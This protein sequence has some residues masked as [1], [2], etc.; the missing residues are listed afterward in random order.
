M[1]PQD[2]F[3]RVLQ[4]VCNVFDSYS[5]VLFLPDPADFG[6][7]KLAASFSLGDN[8]R[9]GMTLEPGQGL[10]GWIVREGKPL[11]ISSFDRKRGVL[12]YY[13]GDVESRIRAFLGVPLAGVKGAL[14]LD[15]KKVH[16][17]GEKEQK[18]LSEFAALVS[19]LY[20]ERESITSGRAE[21][22]LCRCLHEM[23]DLHRRHPK[24]SVYLPR[25]LDEVS[26]A[27][28]FGHCLLAV[29]DDTAKVFS[30]EGVNQ[31]IFHPGLPAPGPFPL[32]AGMIGWVFK[33]G[34]PV[35]ASDADTTAQRLFGAPAAAPVFKSV[36]CQPVSFSRRVWAVL[37]LAGIDQTALYGAHKQFVR[38]AADQMALFLEAL[39]LRGRLAGRRKAAG[40]VE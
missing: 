7:S 4:L 9:Q 17:F 38:A 37:V 36:I 23:S 25:F 10:A 6:R 11:L 15:S 2:V 34:A 26:K 3:A 33:N 35:Y 8:V 29:R 5:A 13:S 39:H 22:G 40:R 1:T 30:L 20:L 12:G 16:G 14:C 28:G 32:G 27:T 31:R 24:W 21:T 18:I 19:T